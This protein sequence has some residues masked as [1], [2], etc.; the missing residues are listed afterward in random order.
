[1]NV[2]KI[3]IR[4]NVFET[5]S[6]SQHS[7]CVMKN[8]EYYTTEEIMKNFHFYNGNAVWHI[9]EDDLKF[10]RT[11][12]RTLATFKNK[13]L[14]ACAS[15]VRTYNDEIYKKLIALALKYV[16]TL[17]SIVL[18]IN[19]DGFPD[20]NDEQNKNDEFAQEYGKTE[21]ELIEYLQQKEKEWGMK[22]EYWKTEDGWWLFDAPF[23]GY[24]DEDVVSSFLEKEQITLEE[25]LTNKKYIVIQDGDK[26]RYWAEIKASG[27]I[28]IELIDYEI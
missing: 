12:F 10:G 27:L 8:S 9:Y 25:F 5:N 24:V 2:I 11:P 3:Q 6:S 16:P 26:Y 17:T 23:T 18:P 13:W 14:Y 7:L 4:R 20:I 21:D 22:I 1:M 19:K 15:M 28:N